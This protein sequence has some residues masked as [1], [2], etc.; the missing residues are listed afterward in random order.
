MTAGSLSCWPGLARPEPASR[1]RRRR[2]PRL[3]GRRPARYV[4]PA[5]SASRPPMSSP[6]AGLTRRAWVGFL[7]RAAPPTSSMRTSSSALDERLSKWP[8]LTPKISWCSIR[9]S[10]SFGFDPLNGHS[11]LPFFRRFATRWWPQQTRRQATSTARWPFFSPGL[12]AYI[13][14]TLGWDLDSYEALEG[15]FAQYM[16]NWAPPARSYATGILANETSA[17]IHMVDTPELFGGE[18][19]ILAAVD[20]ADGKI[21]RWVDYWDARRS[22]T[23]LYAQ[24]RTPADSFPD[25]PEGWRGR[26]RRPHPSSSTAA[27]ALQRAFARGRRRGA[28]GSCTPTSSS[29]TWRCGRSDRA[30][31]DRRVPRPRPRPVPYGRA[32]TLRHVVGGAGV[33]GSSGPLGPSGGLVGITAHRA[34][35]RR[36]DHQ[37][38]VGLR[39]ARARE[40][41]AALLAA[42]FAS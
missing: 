12:V 9:S 16:P 22:T 31:R 40:R 7:L 25:G 15:D 26:R 10:A 41:R 1:S 3:S 13:D 8:P 32:S 4:S 28:A 20:F 30:D 36:A 2:S 5:L 33:A 11:A 27:T 38:H 24:F 6:S 17:L 29:R 42:T 37:D 14:A 39:L 34:R 21:V 18:L 35:R 23:S 19:R